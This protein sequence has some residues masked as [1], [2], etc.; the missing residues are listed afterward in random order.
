MKEQASLGTVVANVRPVYDSMQ[1]GRVVSV[2]DYT[3]FGRIEVIFLDYSKPFPVWVNGSID[4]KP[5]E[6][7]Q[8]L[9]G[10]IQGRQDAPYLAGFV[11]NESYTSNFMLI[12]KDKIILQLPADAEDLEASMLDD[13]KKAKRIRVELTASGV[14]IA[15]LDT[16]IALTSAGIKVAGDYVAC[17]GDTVKVDVPGVGVCTGTITSGASK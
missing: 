12:E 15:G 11:R 4:R 3:K 8:V 2:S 16:S 17:V 6:G 14:V 7:D 10:F 9:V 13:S 1:I 5:S